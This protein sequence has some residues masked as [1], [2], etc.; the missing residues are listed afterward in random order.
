M[1]P[2]PFS[3]EN[4]TVFITGASSGIGRAIAIECSKMGANL[5]ITGR[6]AERLTET[7]N[8]LDGTNHIQVIADFRMKDQTDILLEKLP[9]L[10]G[11]VYSAGI[12]TTLPFQFITKE[13]LD[14]IFS[15]N[16]S[17]PALFSQQLLKQKKIN[18]GASF[19]WIS[20]IAGNL[21]VSPGSSIYSASKSAINGLV[22]GMAL[23]LSPKGIRVNSVNPG[24]IETGIFN[25]GIISDE[26]LQEEIKKYPLKRYGKPEEVAYA[27]IYLL[28][29]ASAWV[30]GSHLI[31]DGGYTLL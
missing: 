28:S 1:I 2:N 6:N 30:T 4:K 8:Q 10:D 23:D 24:V 27:T 11:I 9:L 16:F 22:K 14:E 20:S 18:K 19:V 5:I 3:L 21:C 25:A 7:F 15:I 29:D 26:Q 13:K 12:V 31:I 17:Y